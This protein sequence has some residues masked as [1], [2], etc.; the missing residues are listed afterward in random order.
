M[1]DQ[2]DNKP[3]PSTDDPQAA[4]RIGDMGGD[5]QRG[6]RTPEEG[7]ES[8]DGPRPADESAR[9]AIPSRTFNL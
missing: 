6:G 7:E 1:T 3:T 2:P 9:S 5:P 8:G 4:D